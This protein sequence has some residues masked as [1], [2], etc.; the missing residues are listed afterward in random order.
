MAQGCPLVV[1][2]GGDGTVNEVAQGLAGSDVVL[3][4]MPLGSV[5]NV[6][7]TL[8]IPRDLEERRPP[9][10]RG[11]TLDDGPGPGQQ[12]RRGA[13]TSWKPPAWGWTRPSSATSTGW[14][15][16]PP[17]C[18]CC[19]RAGTSSAGSAC[20]GCY[21][22]STAG[23]AAFWAPMVTVANSPFLGAAY[24]IAPEALIDDGWLDVVLF[25]RLSTLHVMF[26]LLLVA[27]GRP[28]PRPRGVESL[29]A[30]RISVRTAGA[31]PGPRRRRS[32]GADPGDVRRRAPRPAGDRGPAGAKEERPGGVPGGRGEHDDGPETEAP[33]Q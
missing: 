32:P 23:R 10:R 15:R 5:M 2:A 22:R 6:A 29:R 33:G 4:V 3:G 19:A 16:A 18:R 31:P 1:A 13:P 11:Q 24:A 17:G 8:H 26:Y 25:H 7:R 9:H 27:G 28:F 12:R 30:R 20:P 21:W 14:T